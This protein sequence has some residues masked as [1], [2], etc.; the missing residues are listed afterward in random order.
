VDAGSGRAEK[1]ALEKARELAEK[2]KRGPLPGKLN[3]QVEEL[4]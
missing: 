1:D 3:F 2:I 4:I